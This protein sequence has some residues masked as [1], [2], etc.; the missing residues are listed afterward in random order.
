LNRYRRW[1]ARGRG[2]VWRIESTVYYI[3]LMVP[4]LP[5]FSRPVVIHLCSRRCLEAASYANSQSTPL[6]VRPPLPAPVPYGRLVHQLSVAGPTP[7]PTPSHP[8]PTFS[9]RA[10][11]L[12]PPP[13][14]PFICQFMVLFILKKIFMVNLWLPPPP[15][16]SCQFLLLF[17]CR[18]TP[19]GIRSCPC[20]EPE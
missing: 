10:S 8:Y 3:I 1:E 17:R 13:P 20:H 12:W 9:T 11:D 7:H 4:S 16:L 6:P 18:I 19:L 2:G 5:T 14:A 15:A